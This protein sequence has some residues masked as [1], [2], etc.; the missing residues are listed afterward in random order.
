MKH[1]FTLSFLVGLLFFTCGLQ[2]TVF[3][4]CGNNNSFF[5]DLTPTGNGNTQ[6]TNCINAGQYATVTVCA[7]VSYVFSTCGNTAFDTYMTLINDANGA[8]LDWNDDACGLQS[9]ITFAAPINGVVRVLIDEYASIFNTCAHNST[10]MTLSVTQNGTCGQTPNNDCVNAT[11][12]CDNSTFADNSFGPG[13]NDFASANNNPDCLLLNEHQ[14]AWYYIEIAVGG[15]LA[16]DLAPVAGAGEDYDFAIF[17]PDVPCNNLGT[18]IRCSYAD[19]FCLYCPSTGLGNGTTDFSETA[20]GDGYVAEIN[21]LT[22][23]SFYILIDNWLATSQG[24]SLTWTGTAVLD[25]SIVGGPIVTVINVGDVICFGTNTGSVDITVTS[26]TPAYTYLWSN[27]ATTQDLTNVPA[28]TYSVTVTDANSDTDIATVVISQPPTLTFNSSII[29]VSC[30]GGNNGAI[31]LTI[32]GG[33]PPFSYTWSN[34]ANTEDISNLVAGTYVVAI[35]DANG[36]TLSLSGAVT[37]P[38][39]LQS[40]LNAVDASCSGNTGSIDLSV[41][42]GTPGYTYAWSNG[43]TSQDLNGLAGGTYTV[44]ITDAANCTTTNNA[45][46]AQAGAM[47]QSSNVT[48]VSCA[49]AQDGQIDMTVSGGTPPY[50]YAWSNGVFTEDNS[51][52]SGGTYN[53]TVF[54]ANNCTLTFSQVIS[55]PANLSFSASI[56]DVTCNGANDGQIDMTINGGTTPYGYNW[57][58][59]QNTEDISGLSAGT[60]A[61]TVSDLNGCSVVVA[62]PVS[63]PPLLQTAIN[64]VNESC[65]P[66]NDG[67]VDLLAGGGTGGYLYTWSNGATTQDL[68]NLPAGTYNVTVSDANNCQ[69]INSAVVGQGTPSGPATIWRWTG[70]MSTDWFDPCNWDKIVVPTLLNDVYIP[71]STPNNPVVVGDTA[72]CKSRTIRHN[73]GGHIDIDYGNNGLMIIQP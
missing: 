53:L 24:F 19:A 23:Q 44:T 10:C 8:A 47:N 52:L 38:P 17:G 16:F 71:G 64:S 28:G 45:T 12:I 48:H 56:S 60:Y 18:P 40:A 2:S 59:G 66:G 15:T 51:N 20:F 4:Q 61:L 6:T 5:I 43:N 68:A 67:S 65:S 31:N 41:G 9:E 46:I 55:E 37:Q 29:D 57:N 21:A 42:G 25:C 34:G 63:E 36:C 49:G 39:A 7:N 33:T 70:I 22:G 62:G 32:S 3:A 1:I 27:G 35:N 69:A 30:Q 54:D 72:F 26:G 58:S 13:V 73:Q 50:V 14:S 11:P